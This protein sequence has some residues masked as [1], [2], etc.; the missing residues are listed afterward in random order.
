ML[1]NK[2]ALVTGSASGIGLAVAKSFVANGASVALVDFSKNVE[3]ISKQ[4]EADAKAN[5]VNVSAH[6]CDVSKSDQVNKLFDD[7]NQA[8]VSFKA[9]NVIINSAGRK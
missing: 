9:P 6:I 3:N 2:L 1:A 7:V 5:N 8:H 4:L